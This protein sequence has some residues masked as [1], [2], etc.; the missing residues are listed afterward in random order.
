M[1]IKSWKKCKKALQEEISSEEYNAWISPLEFSTNK[2]P[3]GGKDIF[4][5]APNAFI[6]EHV[7]ENYD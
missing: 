4:I 6:K 1:M 2:S 7:R 5:L 3:S